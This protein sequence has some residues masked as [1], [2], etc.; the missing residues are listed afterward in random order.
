VQPIPRADRTPL[1]RT[2][3]HQRREEVIALPT[4]KNGGPVSGPPFFFL[5]SNAALSPFSV[6]G[7]LKTIKAQIAKCWY[8]CKPVYTLKSSSLIK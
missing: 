2:S 1:G 6:R 4:S 8:A 7:N 5:E 3:R